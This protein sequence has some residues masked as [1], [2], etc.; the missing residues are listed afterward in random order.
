MTAKLL[1]SADVAEL[2]T[3]M[4]PPHDAWSER[5]AREWLQRPDA[6][7]NTPGV[8]VC[9]KWYT[10]L[11]RLREHHPL[12]YED[13]VERAAARALEAEETGELTVDELRAEVVQLR[14]RLSET[15]AQLVE[16]TDRLAGRR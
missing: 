14:Q 15:E 6:H 12:A 2:L 10:S 11:E 7:G 5:R 13:A 3:R 1:T 4:S 9:G 8:K 16:L